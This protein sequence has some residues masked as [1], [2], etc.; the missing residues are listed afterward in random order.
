MDE[1]ETS[2]L[3]IIVSGVTNPCQHAS[4]NSV[5]AARRGEAAFASGCNT[6]TKQS[7]RE[8]CEDVC[9]SRKLVSTFRYTKTYAT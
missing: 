3:P 8:N 1:G 2:L 6:A 9:C 5:A 4:G 7:A